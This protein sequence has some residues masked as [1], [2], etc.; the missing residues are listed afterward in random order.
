MSLEPAKW[1]AQLGLANVTAT[2]VDPDTG[3]VIV[4]TSGRL[5][6]PVHRVVESGELGS[7]P[8]PVRVAT[9]RGEFVE[10]SRLDDSAPWSGG[11]KLQPT[12]SL[13]AQAYCTMGFVWKKWG[14]GELMG[15]TA[16]HCYEAQ[17]YTNWYNYGTY[18]GVR[19]YYDT[20]ADAMFLRSSPASQFNP[21]VFVGDQYT[22]TL[23]W[24][25]GASGGPILNAP[26]A[27]SGG[28]S[29]LTVGHITGWGT[30]YLGKGPIVMT[31]LSTCIPGDSGSPWLTTESDGDVIAHGQH[32]GI[33]N[34]SCGFI[35]VQT[36]SA[37]LS[38]SIAVH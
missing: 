37:A 11:G 3:E 16:E 31:S 19:Y 28:N 5:S 21:N 15:S 6:T 2:G 32:L 26:V 14:S 17:H 13:A 8:V 33:F 27:L 25:V 1:A 23:R 9:S 24:V 4:Y 10:Q 34:G 38:A 30:Y 7:G 12:T 20:Q 22:T 36:I 35:H 18:V 29:G